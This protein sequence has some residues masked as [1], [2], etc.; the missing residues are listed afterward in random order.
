MDEIV[1]MRLE[2]TMADLLVR[3]SPTTYGPHITI[4]RGKTVIYVLIA[5]TL[6]GTLKAALLFWEH[7]TAKLISW[8]FEPNPYDQCVANK[9]INGSQC[10]VIWHVDDLKISHVSKDL[11]TSIIS[12][13]QAE[14]GK[15]APLTE[16]RGT[17]HDYLGMKIDFSTLGRVRF[18]MEDYVNEM[19]SGA[20]PDMD[21]ESPTPAASHLFDINS[22][23]PVK[24]C[25][26]R[27]DIFHHMTAQLL[28]LSKRARPDTNCSRIFVYPREIT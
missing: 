7:L 13:L 23:S 21:G 18:T 5:K 15:L 4:E 8:G 11:V 26:S 25:P 28:F 20:P 1:H 6:Y 3:M 27:A 10:T 9:I 2:G 16:T 17:L 22:D 19:I 12:L 14:Y 24:L